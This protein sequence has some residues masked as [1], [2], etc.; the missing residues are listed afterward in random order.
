MKTTSKIPILIHYAI[1]KKIQSVIIKKKKHWHIYFQ[2]IKQN[3]SLPVPNKPRRERRNLNQTHVKYKFI[4]HIHILDNQIKTKTLHISYDWLFVFVKF[5]LVFI[6]CKS[7][8][9]TNTGNDVDRPI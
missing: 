2:L 5:F 8:R 3:V 6:P 4:S 9:L 1:K 7:Q